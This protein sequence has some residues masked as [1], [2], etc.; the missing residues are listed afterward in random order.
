[1]P[2]WSTEPASS[3]SA[4]K[5]DWKASSRPYRRSSGP[6]AVLNTGGNKSWSIASALQDLG[7]EVV[8]TSVRKATEADGK[9]PGSIWGRRGS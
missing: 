2:I 8:A 4:R 9:K 7:I 5:P 6:Q 3:S 1:M